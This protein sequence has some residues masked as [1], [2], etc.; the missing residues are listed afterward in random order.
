MKKVGLVLM[1]F[2]FIGG[3]LLA[4]GK[5]TEKKMS[6]EDREAKMI[7]YLTE[8]LFLTSDEA[9]EFWPVFKSMKE[10][11][12]ENHKDFKTDKPEKDVKIDEMTDEEVI[13]LLEKG[14]AMKQKDLDIKKSYNQKFINIIG[15]KR[16]AKLYHLEKEFN[17]SQNEG[18]GPQGPPSGQH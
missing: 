4:Q 9:K 17:K 13:E 6:K 2:L 10:E 5:P 1:T 12:K 3:S 8:K 7:G 14:F 18:K 11:V 15:P 16:T